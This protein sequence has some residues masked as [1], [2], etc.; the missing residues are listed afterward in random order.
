MCRL[1]GRIQVTALLVALLSAACSERPSE[2]TPTAATAPSTDIFL[3]TLLLDGD[4]IEVSELINITDRAGYDNQPHFAGHGTALLYTSARDS[5]QTDI[6]RY[7]IETGTVTQVTHTPTA[8]EY[9]PTVMPGGALFS[10]IREEAG[11]QGLWQYEMDGSEGG[12]VLDHVQPVGYHAWVDPHSVAVFVLGDSIAPSTLQ[13]ADLR[14]GATSI[15]AENVGRSL[16]RIPGQR[17]ISFVHK[18]SDD[19]WLIKAVDVDTRSVTTI[20]PTLPGSEDYAWLSANTIIMGSESALY[21]WVEGGQ[22]ETVSDLAEFGVRG[23]SRVAVSVA[24]GRIAVVGERG[25]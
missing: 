23:I 8:S 18:P 10:S 22:W 16:H 25:E 15:V 12:G 6:Y 19:E 20:T 1:A 13:L 4:R 14:S 3:G 21:R 2:Y 9:S 11:R 5:R 17:K 24:G 7:D